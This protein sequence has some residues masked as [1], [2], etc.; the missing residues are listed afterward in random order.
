ME[1]PGALH[2]VQLTDTHLRARPGD[3]LRGTDTEATLRAVLDAVAAQ[4]LPDLFLL[5]GDLAEDPA[6]ETYARLRDLVG[7]TG[8]PAWCLPGN[9]DDP[10]L[11]HSELNRDGL[12]TPRAK[13]VAGWLIVLLDSSV[14]GMI[15]GELGN[16]ELAVLADA[17]ASYPDEPAL[18]ALHHPPVALGS[19][20]IDAIGLADAGHLFEILD[21]NPHVRAVV[22]GHAHQLWD[23]HWENA[24]LLGTPSTCMQ[25]LPGADEFALDERPPGWRRMWLHPDGKVDTKVQWLT[26]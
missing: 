4:G 19:R 10:A 11:M 17:L 6:R 3:T 16:A 7:N 8:V 22:W 20:W 2:V 21:V 23:G 18:V 12:A 5:T 25:F 24:R 14:P 1:D 15:G 13:R 9:H 26:D